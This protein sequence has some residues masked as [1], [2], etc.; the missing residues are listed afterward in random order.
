MIAKAKKFAWNKICA[1][2]ALKYPVGASLLLLAIAIAF[3]AHATHHYTEKQLD[4]LAARVGKVF[5][6][7]TVDDQGPSFLSNPAADARSFH[8][9]AGP[10][11][12]IEVV[13]R[14]NKNPYYKV[15]FESGKEGYIRPEDFRE[16]FN[17]TIMTLDPQAD[18]KKKAAEAAEEEKQRIGWIEAQPWSRAVKE[19]AI[20]RQVIPG[21]NRTEVKKILGDPT[22]VSKF[23]ILGN[24]TEEQWVYG[25]RSVVIFHNDLLNRVES[26]KKPAG[27]KTE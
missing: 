23:K 4:A 19:A 8:A 24:V 5:W 16:A 11:E 1:P 26:A 6:V 20:K 14:K 9:E 13:G 27:Q 3:S 2:P 7:V 10:F 18:E 15:R 12:I 22:R 17:V 25:D 21:M